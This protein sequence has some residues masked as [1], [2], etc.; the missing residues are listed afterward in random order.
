[1]GCYYDK[2]FNQIIAYFLIALVDF[3]ND[4]EINFSDLDV[5]LF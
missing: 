3:N 2:S 1:M 5:Y 4:N